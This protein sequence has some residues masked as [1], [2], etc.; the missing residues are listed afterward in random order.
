MSQENYYKRH[1]ADGSAPLSQLDLNQVQNM[2]HIPQLSSS[3]KRSSRRVSARQSLIGAPRTNAPSTA[4]KRAST[5]GISEMVQQSTMRSAHRKSMGGSQS[6]SRPTHRASSFGLGGLSLSQSKDS[7]P[8]RDRN[9]QQTMQKDIFDFLVSHNFESEMKH[10][11]TAKTL[12]N[13]T[14]KDFVLIFQFLYKKVDPGYRFTKS[15]EHEVYYVLRNIKYPFLESINKSQISAVG[16]QNWPVFLGILDW[17]VNLVGKIERITN[18]D[19]L[20]DED[21]GDLDSSELEL[22]KIFVDYIVKSYN[23]FLNN[24]DD[25]SQ[26][27]DEMKSVYEMYTEDIVKQSAVFEKENV[28]LKDMYQKLVIESESLISVEKKSEAL[29]SD[30]FKFK[31]YIESMENRKLK[32]NVVLQQIKQEMENSEL[33]LAHT[34]EEKKQIQKQISDQGLTP[35]DID[36]MNNERDRVS[37]AIDAVNQRL[38]EISKIVHSKEMEAQH[39]YEELSATLKEYNFK[40]Y[41]IASTSPD[42]DASQFVIKLDNLLSEDRLGLRPDA[43]LDGQDLKTNIR[44]G[45]QKLKNEISSRIHKAQEDGISLQEKLDSLSETIN[46]KTEHV[47]SLEAKL[48]GLKLDYEDL[49]ENMSKDAT[50]YHAEIERYESELKQMQSNTKQNKLLLEQHTKT[51]DMEYKK[52]ASQVQ[53]ER[54]ILH[55][56]AQKMMDTVITFKLNIQGSL[57]DLENMVVDELEKEKSEQ[58]A[59]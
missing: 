9:Y 10:P 41:T 24:I 37:K 26:F 44:L 4:Q 8:L 36:R 42:L 16:G 22:E 2:S 7:R 57:E 46:E 6:I 5:T 14:Q 49:Y 40:I 18:F 54:E 33:E 47:E 34:E 1:R 38:N 20:V 52:L 59:V 12:K 13:P 15:I 55:S 30:L 17:L 39:A 50:S 35:K 11:L 45:L 23:A 51:I 29:D 31:A 58:I 56:K 27:Y 28:T 32:W 53:H 19:D 3:L 25:Y 48:S 21:Y 43:I